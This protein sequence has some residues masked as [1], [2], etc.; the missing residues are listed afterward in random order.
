MR[1]RIRALLATTVES[2]CAPADAAAAYDKA[3][4]LVTKY[5]FDRSEFTW[6]ERPEAAAMSASE[7]K[8][9]G[10]LARELL[11]KHRD[12]SHPR[13]AEEV[14]TVL[15]S[16]ASPASVAWYAARMCR[17]GLEVGRVRRTKE[18]AR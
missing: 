3:E 2:G 4:D 11:L 14:N 16:K 10:R 9:V 6:P 1:H 17:E 13:I 8:G 5:G 7:P 12:W 18:Q 15:G